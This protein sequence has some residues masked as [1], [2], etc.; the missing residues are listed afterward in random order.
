MTCW[1]R[2]RPSTAS[3]PID[4]D[5]S[6]MPLPLAASYSG[7]SPDLDFKIPKGPRRSNGRLAARRSRQN[8]RNDHSSTIPIRQPETPRGGRFASSAPSV[9][10]PMHAT[11][12]P[13]AAFAKMTAG[14][15]K[16]KQTPARSLMLA[17]KEAQEAQEA[18]IR[19]ERSESGS[20][21]PGPS[22]GSGLSSRIK[23]LVNRPGVASASK[24]KRVKV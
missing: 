1:C 8:L 14:G 11:P 21:T 2:K 13:N 5:S 10:S 17:T 6:S 19:K 16:P 4:T 15:F 20:T 23:D 12:S 18:K 3:S 24:G 9:Y 22:S 7:P